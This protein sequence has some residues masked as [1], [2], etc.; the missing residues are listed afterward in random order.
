MQLWF[1]FSVGV[2]HQALVRKSFTD[3]ERYPEPNRLICAP[4]LQEKHRVG[5]RGAQPVGKNTPGRSGT[6]DDVV[7]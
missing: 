5:A 6:D 1:G 2:P 4:C 7:V 3:A